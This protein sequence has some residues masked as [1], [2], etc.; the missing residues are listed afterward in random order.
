M[1]A[2]SL[3]HTTSLAFTGGQT[4]LF[5]WCLLGHPRRTTPPWYGRQTSRRCR[6]LDGGG[7]IDSNNGIHLP[8][9][10]LELLYS[11]LTF[12]KS[13]FAGTLDRAA[14]SRSSRKKILFAFDRGGSNPSDLTTRRTDQTL[15]PSL[16][17]S[18]ALHP[19]VKTF[20]AAPA[21]PSRSALLIQGAGRVAFSLQGCRVCG[22]KRRGAGSGRRVQG[23]CLPTCTSTARG[24]MQQGAD[25]GARD[26]VAGRW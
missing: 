25:V 5:P 11:K 6:S 22:V 4:F 3:A 14:R 15:P 18:R 17:P 13:S 1:A 24:A 8:P 16:P 7:K 23:A 19:C 2:A 12:H 26:G 9:P 10:I 20:R 21:L